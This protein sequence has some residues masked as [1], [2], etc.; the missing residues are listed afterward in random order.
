MVPVDLDPNAHP[1]VGALAQDV[2][3]RAPCER[4]LRVALR[5]RE[6]SKPRRYVHGRCGRDTLGKL[7]TWKLATRV[8]SCHYATFACFQRA[9]SCA[10]TLLSSPANAAWSVS[11]RVS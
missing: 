10:R 7:A 3:I 4:K 8:I 6:P 9:A 1:S 2:Q 5:L 11:A